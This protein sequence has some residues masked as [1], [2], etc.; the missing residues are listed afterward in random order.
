M[1]N[2]EELFTEGKKEKVNDKKKKVVVKKKKVVATKKLPKKTKSYTQY[3]GVFESDNKIKIENIKKDWFAID[4]VFFGEE[5]TP[6]RFSDS[7]VK[8]WKETKKNVLSKFYEMTDY[9][10]LSA[11]TEESIFTEA[12]KKKSTPKEKAKKTAKK[13]KVEAKKTLS[14]KKKTV[15][16]I[17]KKLAESVFY[18]SLLNE[19]KAVQN[20]IKYIF[21]A[22]CALHLFG[23]TTSL[24]NPLVKLYAIYL[25]K[26]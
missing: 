11:P 17:A 7:F 2:F 26:H 4:Y 19:E 23:G 12:A 1:F 25:K 13:A 15:K 24:V 18:P 16:K 5:V 21:K 9:I 22:E 20:A 3:G 10:S 14:K 8:K 6:E